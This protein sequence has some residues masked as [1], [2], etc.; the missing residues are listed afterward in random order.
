M[1]TSLAPHIETGKKGE[2]IAANYLL[3]L[4]YRIVQRNVRV[5]QKD[6]IDIIAF[7]PEDVV[8]VFAEVKT[9]AHAGDYLPDIN[10]TFQKRALMVRAARN[11]MS[12]LDEEAGW[13]MDSVSVVGEN[14]TNHY[15]EVRG[16][17][18]RSKFR[19]S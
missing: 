7:D 3:S 18:E 14:V 8:Y 2:I 11:Y 4:G 15:K 12:K 17:E 10:I 13:R 5:G 19:F 9:R 16:H 1:D 6:E